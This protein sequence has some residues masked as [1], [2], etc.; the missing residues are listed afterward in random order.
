MGTNVKKP[1]MLMTWFLEAGVHDV[2]GAV[3][4]PR[5][6]GP[7]TVSESDQ[8]LRKSGFSRESSFGPGSLRESLRIGPPAGR[9]PD[10]EVL[11]IRIRPK[12]G[13]KVLSSLKPAFLGVRSP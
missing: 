5:S 9:W 10:F 7:L 1:H 3:C 11:P 12:P 8:T 6:R 4:L 13:P 2:V